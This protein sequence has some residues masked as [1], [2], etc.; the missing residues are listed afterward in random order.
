[1]VPIVVASSSVILGAY[2]VITRCDMYFAKKR[3]E[4]LEAQIESVKKILPELNKNPNM[5]RKD[6]MK[7]HPIV[8]PSKPWGKMLNL[9]QAE[10]LSR[11]QKMKIQQITKRSL[12][13]QTS[14]LMN[15]NQ[16]T[17]ITS[18]DSYTL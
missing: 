1:M 14:Q 15:R 17:Q 2:E 5:T 7:R 8:N 4:D 18:S 6:A 13:Y 12:I 16:P 10:A 3:N 9:D 11:F